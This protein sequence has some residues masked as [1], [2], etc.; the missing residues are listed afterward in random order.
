MNSAPAESATQSIGEPDPTNEAEASA[1]PVSVTLPSAE[2]PTEPP[3]IEEID[4]LRYKL[5]SERVRTAELL[6][7]MYTRELQRAVG[8]RETSRHEFSKFMKTVQTKYD[9]N[10]RAN[11]ITDDG[12]LVPRPIQQRG[13]HIG[14]MVE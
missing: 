11:M 13:P 12:Y 10:L 5:C 8:E 1:L 7:E 14:G 3:K 9:V 4:L 6:V 2:G